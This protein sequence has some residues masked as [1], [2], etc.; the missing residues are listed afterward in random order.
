MILYFTGTGN[1]YQLAKVIADVTGDRLVS[2][3][4][5][6]REG[7]TSALRSDKP[8]V[9]V[10]PIYAGRIPHVVTEHIRATE[11]EGNS[12]AYFA[13]TCYQTPYKARVYAQKVCREKGLGFRGLRAVLMPQNYV[14]LTAPPTSEE[15]ADIIA[16]AEPQMRI[17]A[18]DIRDGRMLTWEE[19]GG[20]AMSNAANPI[21]Y[22]TYLSAKGFRAMD[23]C[24]GCGTCE[25]V[26]PLGNIDLEGGKPSWGDE[27]T[28]CMACI[29]VCPAKAVEFK[30][31]T[32]GRPRFWNP[33]YPIG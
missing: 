17:I 23:A 8:F 1:S 20:G 6:I 18:E 14:V 10:A 2:M 4:A 7:D 12:E 27:C 16:K 15:A 26:C 24:T 28:H 3:N 21:F 19:H 22:R 5:R 32:V 9:F 25:R 30:D 13:V 11:F 31:K 29:N 33:A